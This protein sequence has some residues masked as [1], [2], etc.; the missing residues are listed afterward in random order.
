MIEIKSFSFAH[1]IL[2]FILT[3]LVSVVGMKKSLSFAVKVFGTYFIG[4]WA[5]LLFK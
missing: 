3:F 1:S 2:V 4:Y 5:F